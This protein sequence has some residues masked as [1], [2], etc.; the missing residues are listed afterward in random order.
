LFRFR[1]SPEEEVSQRC[2]TETR[3]E[4]SSEGVK[5]RR[6]SADEIRVTP[7]RRERTFSVYKP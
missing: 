1:K 3:G 7:L 2:E 5:A 4:K 6:G